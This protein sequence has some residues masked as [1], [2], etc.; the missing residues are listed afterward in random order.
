MRL[1]PWR[2]PQVVL[3]RRLRPS[4]FKDLQECN[5]LEKTHVAG[6]LSDVNQQACDAYDIYCD[7][8]WS[9]NLTP[10]GISGSSATSSRVV[11]SFSMGKNICLT[12]GYGYVKEKD[13]FENR[14]ITKCLHEQWHF[15]LLTDDIVP[16]RSSEQI[17]VVLPSDSKR[18]FVRGNADKSHCVNK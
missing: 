4:G 13:S 3:S 9:S 10:N 7:Q 15:H 12:E 18:L 2:A 6:Q 16:S 14:Q 5:R 8:S 11:S 17:T 1:R